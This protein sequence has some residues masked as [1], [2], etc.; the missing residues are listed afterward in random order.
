MNHNER[1]DAYKR[2]ME[3]RISRWRGETCLTFI[4]AKRTAVRVRTLH[5]LGTLHNEENVKPRRSLSKSGTRGPDCRGSFALF[6][7]NGW[8]VIP[9]A[10]ECSS[11]HG[12][13]L[14]PQRT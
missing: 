6:Q 3:P 8:L 9:S 2:A 12:A 4:Y 5:T 13:H 11:L 7:P 10:T 14:S 1:A